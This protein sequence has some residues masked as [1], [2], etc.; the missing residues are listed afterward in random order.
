MQSTVMADISPTSRPR[1]ATIDVPSAV[2]DE[3]SCRAARDLRILLSARR[4]EL[5]GEIGFSFAVER[6]KKFQTSKKFKL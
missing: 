2:V 6:K 3:G 1:G 4:A 5:A